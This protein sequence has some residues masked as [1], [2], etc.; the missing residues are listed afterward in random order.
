MPI[1]LDITELAALA[2][3]TPLELHVGHIAAPVKCFYL[4]YDDPKDSPP[5]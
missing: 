4:G 2:P 3:L 5:G 1:E